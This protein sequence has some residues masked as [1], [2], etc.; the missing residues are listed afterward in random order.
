MARWRDDID[1]E[2]LFYGGDYS[3][4]SD[5]TLHDINQTIIRYARGAP[6]RAKVLFLGHVLGRDDEDANAIFHVGNTYYFVAVT[7]TYMVVMDLHYV[8][9]SMICRYWDSIIHLP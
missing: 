5:G 7:S 9:N 1:Y 6:V 4:I 8:R 2:V 3:H